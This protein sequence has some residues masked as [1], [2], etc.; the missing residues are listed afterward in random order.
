MGKVIGFLIL[1][2]LS[3]FFWGTAIASNWEWFMVPL[4][5]PALGFWH[6]CGMGLMV[7]GLTHRVSDDDFD[8]A[9]D[10]KKKFVLMFTNA[11]LAPLIILGM[12]WFYHYMMVS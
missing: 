4:G 5:L 7:R 9:E 11:V 3:V 12:G 8:S 6:A 1:M 10:E 2:V